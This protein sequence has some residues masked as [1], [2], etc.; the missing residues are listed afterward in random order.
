VFCVTVAAVA[1]EPFAGVQS[2][3]TTHIRKSEVPCD[4]SRSAKLYAALR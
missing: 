4:P 1:G 3:R 2:A